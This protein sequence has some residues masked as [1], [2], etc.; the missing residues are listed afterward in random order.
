[1]A[2]WM[3][4]ALSMGAAGMT[5]DV[6][7]SAPADKL[8]PETKDRLPDERMAQLVIGPT[9]ALNEQDLALAERRFAVLLAAANA[10]DGARSLTV[11]DLEMSFGL[12]LFTAGKMEGLDGAGD[13][14][15]RHIAQSVKDYAA[16]FGRTH[17]EVA[18]ALSSQSDAIGELYDDGRVEERIPLIRES[19]A[20]R[21]STLDEDNPERLA[22]QVQLIVLLTHP[23]IKDRKYFEEAELLAAEAQSRASAGLPAGHYLSKDRLALAATRPMI[24]MGKIDA[25]V[26]QVKRVLAAYRPSPD[27]PSVC[28]GM[29]KILERISAALVAEGAKAQAAK[30]DVNASSMCL[31]AM[32]K[33][34][35]KSIE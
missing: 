27:D 5:Q 8:Y 2:L 28:V 22:N 4:L 30:V 33:A 11:A 9:D 20:I 15:I 35:G 23:Q 3:A 17:P 1:M 26:G 12:A 14:A 29:T 25:G 13:A 34:A 19:Y 32:L 7:P 6:A 16:H 31:D 18:L 21:Q 10:K 24:R